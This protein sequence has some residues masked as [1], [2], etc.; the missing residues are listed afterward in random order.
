MGNKRAFTYIVRCS[1]D[2]LY[3]GWT[4]DL[5][6]RISEHNSGRGAKYTRGRGPVELMVF[7]ELQSRSDAMRLERLIKAMTRSEKHGLI[8]RQRSSSGMVSELLSRLDM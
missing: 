3:T 6:H 8:K 7:W 5:E 4:V 2:S 1:D